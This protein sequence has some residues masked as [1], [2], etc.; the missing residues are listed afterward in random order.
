MGDGADEAVM[1]MEEQKLGEGKNRV[2]VRQAGKEWWIDDWIREVL[3][4]SL[5]SRAGGAAAFLH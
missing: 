4:S 1:L 5:L 3:G 2:L